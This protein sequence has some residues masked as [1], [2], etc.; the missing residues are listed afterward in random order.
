[1]TQRPTTAPRRRMGFRLRNATALSPAG[2][3]LAAT[4]LLAA[5][6]ATGQEGAPTAAANPVVPTQG[7]ATRLDYGANGVPVVKIAAP[8]AKGTSYNRYD[9]FDVDGRGVVLNNSDRIVQSRLA[10]YIDGNAALRA[11]GGATLII[12]EVVAANPSKLGGYIEVAGRAAD[13]ILANPY[14]IQCN[15]CGFVNAPRV[16]LAAATPLVDTGTV[17]GFRVGA[18]TIAVTGRGLDA[19]NAR[20]ELFARAIEVNAGLYAD[21]V[22][23][24]F[25]AGEITR[26]GDILVTGRRNPAA[27][28]QP[29]FGL[30]VA[31]L[32][33][34]YARSIRLIGTEAGLGVNVSGELAGL[35]QGVALSAD[36]RVTIGGQISART[37][38]GIDTNGAIDVGGQLYAEGRT[39]LR[40]AALTGDGLIGSGGDLAVTAASITR[41]GTLAAGLT[42]DGKVT[43][44]GNLALDVAGTATLIGRALA[45][46]GVTLTA[47]GLRNAGLVSGAAITLRTG[48][49]DNTGG[50]VDARG[51]LDARAGA[52]ANGGGAIQAGGPLTLQGASLANE[53]GAV[54]AL[55]GGRLALT[56]A[57]TVASTDGQIGGNG[58]VA[59][60]AG[61]LAL[62]GTSGALT[63]ARTLA[64]TTAGDLSLGGTSLIAAGGAADLAVGG[65]A[66]L[67]GGSVQAGGAL[68]L[69]AGAI[70]IGAPAQVS[71][72]S[73]TLRTGG[74]LTNA[75]L[76]SSAGRVTM[77][78]GSLVNAGTIAGDAGV[79]I[80]A[81][82]GLAQNGVVASDAGITIDA[83][84]L[85]AAGGT[86]QAGGPLAIT[87]GSAT[88]ERASLL[89]VGSGP[90]TFAS[91]GAVTLT[92][93]RLGGNGAVAVRGGS[94][95]LTRSRVTAL[96]ALGV[97]A[98]GGDLALADASTVEGAGDLSL[99]ATGTLSH[100]AD[101]V[102]RGA[103]LTLVAGRV[104]NRGGAVL[105][106]GTGTLAVTGTG[107]VDNTGG[108]IATNGALVLGGGALLNDRGRVTSAGAS[109]LTL[110]GDLANA[111]GLVAA[112]T[113]LTLRAGTL[114]NVGGTVEASGRLD[115]G[116]GAIDGGTLVSTGTGG[117]LALDV[118]GAITGGVLIGATGDAAITAGSFALAPDARLTAGGTLTARAQGGDLALGG[119]RIEAARLALAAARSILTGG[120]GVVQSTGDLT[121][122]AGDTLSTAGGRAATAGALRATAATIDNRGGTLVTGSG[123]ATLAAGT[124][125]NDRGT[126]GGEGAVTITAATVENGAGVLA[127][128]TDLALTTGS[129]GSAADGQLWADRDARVAV[130]G[131]LANRG[132]I[133]AN[134]DL[135]LT[136]G[137]LDGA[138]GTLAGGRLLSVS[139]NGGTAG[140]LV[141]PTSLTLGIAGDFSNLAGETIS[142]PGT[143]TLTVGGSF[144][145]AGRIE[146]GAIGVT[147]A[148]DLANSGEIVAG[149]IALATNGAL[150]N[151]GL[152]NGGAVTLRG[153]SIAN[154]GAIYGDRVALF[155]ATGIGNVGAGAVIATRNGLLQLSS[156][157]GIVNRD[158]ALL[159][160]LGELAITGADGGGR[161]ASLDNLS[162]DIQA[163]GD[164]AIAATRVTNA[165]AVFGTEEV[166]LSSL[167][168]EDSDRRDR[169]H[170]TVTE[171][172]ETVTDTQVTADSAPARIIGGTVSVDAAALTNRLSTISASGNLSVGAAAVTNEAF[173]GYNTTR[174]SGTIKDQKRNC[175]LF[176]CGDWDTRSTTPLETENA[177]ATFTIPSTITA[178][179]TLA[180]DAVTIDNVTRVPGGG[181][182][183]IFAARATPGT[184]AGGAAVGG[185]ALAGV[186]APGAAPGAIAGVT[187]EPSF[188]FAV[189]PIG[190]RA[191]GGAGGLTLDLGGLF[192]Y[193]GSTSQFLVEAD[194]RFTNYNDF[195]SSDYFLDR[196]GYDPARV[197]RR[198][199][200]G[201]YEQQLIA[202]QLV[203][204]IGV[205]RIQGYGDNQAQYRALLDAGA[206][207]AQSY[208]LAL[209]V[210]LSPAQVATLTSDIVLLVETVVQ[211]PSGP[212]TVL[213]PR[214][215]LTK[216]AQG[217]LTSGGAIIAGRD[218]QL[219]ASSSL[220]N[221]GVLRATASSGIAGGAITNT[222]RLDLGTRGVV[223]ASQDLIDRGG[224]ITG[225]DLTLAAGR[226]LSL[227]TVATT[228][229]VATRYYAGRSDQQV[230]LT[231]TTTNRGTDIAAAGS[232][233]LLAGRSS[234][235]TATTVAAGGNLTLYGGQD[236]AVR[237]ATDTGTAFA[238][239]REGK[240]QYTQT[241]TEQ[242]NTLS[243]VRA[244][245]TAT[246]ATPGQLTVA[247]G[248]IASGGALVA[249]A[250][251]ID[252]T[253]VVDET[254]LE[255]DTLRKSGGLL[256]S[257]KTTTS[258]DGTDRTVIA[259][260]LSGD[261]VALRS[262]GD[263][264]IAGSNVVAD[265][266]LSIR[267]GGAL[268]IG[269]V[270]VTDTETQSTRVKKS[271]LSIGGGG[272]FLG[273]A[274]TQNDVDR[275]ATTNTGSLIGSTAG[276]V[277]LDAGRALTVTGSQVAGTGLTSL[278]GERVVVQNATDTSRTDTL[279][280]SSSVGLSIGIQ[281]PVLS[282]LAGVRD[283]GR[284]LGNDNANARTTAVAGLAGG[285]AAYNAA[286]ALSVGGA[287]VG[288][289]ARDLTAV[290][291][292]FGVSKSRATSTTT[293]EA[294]VA[295]R[296]AGRDVAIAARGAG[297]GST[298]TIQGSEIAANRDL[299]LAAPGA[300]TL[301]SAQ[302]ADTLAQSNRSS[303]FS[304]GAQIGLN[305][306][307]AP[308]AS[309]SLG[310]GNTA[311]TETRNVE[312]LL[313]AGNQVTIATPGAL[314]L[315]GAQVAGDRVVV[316]AGSL[317]IVSDQDR[318]S[319]TERQ[320]NL[321]LSV[322]TAGGGSIAGNLSNAR[323]T[324]DYASVREQ[325][326]IFAGAGGYDIAV[327]GNTNL[328][329]GVLASEA[330]AERNRLSTGTLT[331]SD[332]ANAEQYRASSTTIGAG[333]GG[334]G[335]NTDGGATAGT[336]R[337]PG[338]G[339]PGLATGLGRISA[340]PPIALGARG[341]QAGETRSAIAPGTVAITSGDPA[342]RAVASTISRDT[343]GAN[344]GA[345]TREY[346]A[347]KREE[348]ALGFAAATQLAVQTGTFFANRARDE[349]IARTRADVIGEQLSRGLD[350]Q[351]NPLSEAARAQLAE[352]YT[353]E[354][355]RAQDL[356]DTFGGGSAARIVATALTA[357][358]G[359]NVTGSLGGLVQ[360]AAAN[361]LQSLAATQVKQIA[362][363]LRDEPGT[364]T[365][366]SEVV[367]AALQAVVGCAGAAA[368]GG[369]CGSTA[370]GAA[371]GVVLNYVLTDFARP[372]TPAG[373]QRPIADQQARTN[374]VATVSAAIAGAAGLDPQ[375]FVTGSV[376]ETEN[377]SVCQIVGTCLLLGKPI[378]AAEAEK[379]W[380]AYFRSVDGA[381]AEAAYGSR[382]LVRRCAGDGDSEACQAGQRRLLALQTVAIDPSRVT[383]STPPAAEGQRVIDIPAL[384]A[385]VEARYDREHGAGSYDRVIAA[386]EAERRATA[387]RVAT[388]QAQAD[389]MFICFLA[390]PAAAAATPIIATWAGGYAATTYGVGTIGQIATTSVTGATLNI[391]TQ[392]GQ[393][394]LLGQDTTAGQIIGSGV[395]GAFF[396][397][398][399]TLVRSP[400]LN[401]A[402]TG[403]AGSALGDAVGQSIDQTFG[404][405]KPFDFSQLGQATLL[406]AGAGAFVSARGVDGYLTPPTIGSPRL[407]GQVVDGLN[408]QVNEL[409]RTLS[410]AY[411]QTSVTGAL[412]FTAC[413][414][415]ATKCQG[416]F[417]PLVKPPVAT[418]LTTP[419]PRAPAERGN[420]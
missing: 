254:R 36:G 140:R 273:V 306:G 5:V 241:Q 109:T 363:S 281:N 141:A 309:L 118:R 166:L 2:V 35:E 196:L 212:Q 130:S 342:S 307:I 301:R 328:V 203:A 346:D 389:R 89:A 245:G 290:G 134:H 193:S 86:V 277:T 399:L 228:R 386:G 112:G 325:S 132:S 357:A 198:L 287:G 175:F 219:R 97:E 278:T 14:G 172:T 177:V 121:L 416:V 93:T 295:S 40:G 240:T 406:G 99:R 376:V 85:T 233:D 195:L 360:T 51:A 356:R 299:S 114:R 352:G 110:G 313:T 312:S 208:Q 55:G 297:A 396:V 294:N 155:G 335:R 46:G 92:D 267:A 370:T 62:A 288:A 337:T 420:R 90:L 232:V 374:L 191:S 144:A 314:T 184:V 98:T 202:N 105:H 298:I 333:I 390:C 382:A 218:L 319:Y 9:R 381:R 41:G 158:G 274:K 148:R 29:A 292:S 22:T 276:D 403:G 324:G 15:G 350:G 412:Q 131:S 223:S 48:A 340:T 3:G 279:T 300:I 101:I 207:Y 318:A 170:R 174:Q 261:T 341:S 347:N 371:A 124:L 364:A 57:G 266:G 178:G 91:P 398:G 27:A 58:D 168:V 344:A 73:V 280:K 215:Y 304:V 149:A 362:D 71:G 345:L 154:T 164:I 282:G 169:E 159:Y 18:G 230:S 226:D 34:M 59:V 211:T 37:D 189:R 156:G 338:S 253:G 264:R 56:V 100:A 383:Y 108:R 49:L 339:L 75:G 204:L 384:V 123:G 257:T 291:V 252:V 182:A 67:A 388:A 179:G 64:L 161:A 385:A 143:L 139:S 120:G 256:S 125:R 355:A 152:V 372:D 351:G 401:G 7:G 133:A 387:A 104:D 251:R 395:S 283:A 68:G 269:T 284:V 190:D 410:G 377:N 23:A 379:Q 83:V 25:G 206:T 249:D 415:D 1:M 162:A 50:I 413:A 33:G 188:G 44:P 234:A 129:L 250:G 247:G 194:P 69:T 20:L 329:G 321:G 373:E 394:A 400:A 393:N 150:T 199:G 94:L 95:A 418:P 255:R 137:T 365:G 11:S 61:S 217:D 26:D 358:A 84:A 116:L 187:I 63:A 181:T 270:A 142:T 201:L 113:T 200:D 163:Q 323:Q 330:A 317:A 8:D 209:G 289:T 315:Q 180:I 348:I 43:Q 248:T 224:S 111:G 244:G 367:R 21:T 16:T 171:Y 237:S 392:V 4:L 135:V 349:Q 305:G 186:T 103:N 38:V 119:G 185:T 311:G 205:Q 81:M 17:N 366:R 136:A 378:V 176:F 262:S 52:I 12:N 87:A 243:D 167:F 397:P 334:I 419:V 60:S 303:G 408:I 192:K 53:R 115:A 6:P 404:E 229:T 322:G 402:I 160:S 407:P 28:D 214:V 145:N 272:L 157:G 227:G 302:E 210:G 332:I 197:Q 151:T 78:A 409:P 222:G 32:G 45:Q 147:A 225:G 122:E 127:A 220:A 72:A 79:G 183:D 246:V 285:L 128:G 259:S 24:S 414:R 88:L 268:D 343:A 165:R 405:A 106:L 391:G 216:A 42:R 30:D 66:T 138:G 31:A 76:V 39:T 102:G 336:D 258:Y 65:A 286:D 361:T 54:L 375:S 80:A 417:A 239:G 308:S 327:G 231:T 275:T 353:A 368:G 153:G 380:T 236:V 70:T 354:L 10:G 296:V 320:R 263:T 331:A 260:T 47:G 19:T 13:L 96:G 369:D 271:G 107:A 117:Q 359:S 173:T 82:R 310:R 326:G 146:G 213:A 221:A 316:D 411:I 126:L 238:I 74:A 77:A 293:Q 235:L 265:N 242:R